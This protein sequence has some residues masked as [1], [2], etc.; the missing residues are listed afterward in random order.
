MQVRNASAFDVYAHTGG[1]NYV[2]TGV[3]RQLGVIP[4]TMSPRCENAGTRMDVL[5]SMKHYVIN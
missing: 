2:M 5:E 1:D 4:G 3:W